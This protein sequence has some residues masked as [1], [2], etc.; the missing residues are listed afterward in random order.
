MA[1]DAVRSGVATDF[2]TAGVC[3]ESDELDTVA[4]DIAPVAAGLLN[5]F[6]VRV[7]NARPG[8]QP[9]RADAKGGPRACRGGPSWAGRRG[10]P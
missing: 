10:Q 9:T 1:Y 6:L 7:A 2:L 4:P 3:L 5:Y 8:P